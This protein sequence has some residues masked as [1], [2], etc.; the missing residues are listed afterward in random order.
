MVFKLQS[1]LAM[2]VLNA[3]PGGSVYVVGLGLMYLLRMED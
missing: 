1:L 2:A 3:G